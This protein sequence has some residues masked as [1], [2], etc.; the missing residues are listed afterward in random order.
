MGVP[1]FFRWLSERYPKAL[2]DMI[3]AELTPAD[4]IALSMPPYNHGHPWTTP[5][6]TGPN[7]NGL[8]FDNLYLDCNGIVHP[9]CHPEDGRPLPA[10]EDDMPVVKKHKSSSDHRL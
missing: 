2:V 4:L 7:P 6:C 9:C 3:E 5:D 1:A 8:E 10:S